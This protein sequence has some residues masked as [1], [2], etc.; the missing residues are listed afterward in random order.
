MKAFTIDGNFSN[1]IGNKFYE[2]KDKYSK[3]KNDKPS[4]VV[5]TRYLNKQNDMVNDLHAE[6]RKIQSSDVSDAEKKAKSGEL[7]ELINLIESTAI[8]NVKEY[9]KAVEKYINK[10][11]NN[12]ERSEDYAYLMANKEMFGAEYAVKA[13]STK[14]YNDNRKKNMN[15]VFNEIIKNYSKVK[16][17]VAEQEK[18]TLPTALDIPRKI[19]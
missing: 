19:K 10:F 16:T 18:E 6:I 3:Y 15:T 9:E 2:T 1:E 14:K 11:P 8:M 7:R 12:K 4:A 17:P 13:Y 5:V